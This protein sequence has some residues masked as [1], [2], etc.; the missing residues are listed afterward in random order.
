MASSRIL[1]ALLTLQQVAGDL[2]RLLAAM[3]RSHG[4]LATENLFLRKQL[5]ELARE[6]NSPSHSVPMATMRVPS[7]KRVM[8]AAVAVANGEAGAANRLGVTAARRLAHGPQQTP[9]HAAGHGRA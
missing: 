5:A 9:G 6:R 1:G 2:L 3:V 4:Q 7:T 8:E